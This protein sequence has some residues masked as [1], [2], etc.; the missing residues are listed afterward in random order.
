MVAF[1]A[2]NSPNLR[3]AVK[4]LAHIDGVL[5]DASL[6]LDDRPILLEGA[7]APGSGLEEGVTPT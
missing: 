1:G 5:L 7:F 6:W 4:S 2:N 3:G